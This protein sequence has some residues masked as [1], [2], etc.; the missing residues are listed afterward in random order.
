MGEA[1][2][3]TLA[4]GVDDGSGHLPYRLWKGRK[5]NQSGG[6]VDRWRREQKVLQ[7]YLLLPVP[8]SHL[9]FIGRENENNSG[10]GTL[11]L[12]W[13]L[14]WPCCHPCLSQVGIPEWL[15]S[16]DQP[17]LDPST[18]QSRN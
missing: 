8:L 6:Q 16:P 7:A 14:H 10:N 15:L 1:N 12:N 11:H 4:H 2:Q 13:W 3:R 9:L 17:L 5:G 18:C